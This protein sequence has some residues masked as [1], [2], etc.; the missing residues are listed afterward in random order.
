Y[1]IFTQHFSVLHHIAK[2]QTRELK[3]LSHE[4][5]DSLMAITTTI[6]ILLLIALGVEVVVLFG[7]RLVNWIKNKILMQSGGVGAEL[8]NACSAHTDCKGWGLGP[9]DVACC[10]GICTRKK[11]DWAG[12]GYCP[13]EC[14]GWPFGPAGTCEQNTCP[15]GWQQYAN[16][17]RCCP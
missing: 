5:L 17:K 7:P 14:V 6:I 2:Y 13:N 11:P 8:G 1:S 15:V 4:Y 9:G 3:T 12:I 16:G 10:T